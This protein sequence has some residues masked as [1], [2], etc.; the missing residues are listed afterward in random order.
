MPGNEKVLA[1]PVYPGMTPLDLIG[2]LTV[3][4]TPDWAPPISSADGSRTAT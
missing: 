1:F 4:K 2:P 3:L